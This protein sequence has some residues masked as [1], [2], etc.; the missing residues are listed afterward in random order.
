MRFSVLILTSRFNE[1]QI[2][3]R[4][5]NG[6][7]SDSNVGVAKGYL[8]N[9]L[10]SLNMCYCFIEQCGRWVSNGLIDYSVSTNIRYL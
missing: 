8:G 9:N 4:F 7:C 10:L 1:E 5:R 6:R 3:L 2:T